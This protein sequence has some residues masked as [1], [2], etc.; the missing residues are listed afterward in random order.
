MADAM[1]LALGRIDAG[2]AGAILAALADP[3]LPQAR[4]QD[5]LR[6]LLAEVRLVGANCRAGTMLGIAARDLPV[7]VNVFWP[8]PEAEQLVQSILAAAEP[9]ASFRTPL[10]LKSPNGTVHVRYSSWI[11]EGAPAGELAFGLVDVHDQVQAETKLMHLRAQM[12]HA[13]RLSTLGVMSATIAHEV[14]QP[15]SAML[16]SAQAALRWLRQPHADLGQVEDCLNTIVLGAGKAEETVARLRMMA[17]DRR[18][19]RTSCALRPLIE[20]TA[21]FLQQELASRQA[22]L[23]LDIPEG[24]GSVHADSVQLRQVLINLIMNA[25]QAMAD[26]RCWSR[27]IKVRARRT[28]GPIVVEVEDSGPGIAD[29]DR[30]RLFE[31]FYS[32]KPTGLGL[33]LRICRQI[34]EDHGGTLEHLSKATAGSIFRFTLPQAA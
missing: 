20:E 1:G 12:A 31:G 27:A 6:R 8:F 34:V 29:P 32:T 5:L 15:L 4:R 14:R 9:H 21:E 33:G 23:L 16:T 7:P 19:G 28:G 2:S 10:S 11:E 26:A 24:L 30:D 13:D 18:E 17:S 22:T 3:S 25:A